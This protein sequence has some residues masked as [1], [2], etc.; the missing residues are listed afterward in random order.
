MPYLDRLP[1]FLKIFS[2]L[3]LVSS[4]AAHLVAHRIALKLKQK[5]WS[6][7]RFLQRIAQRPAGPFGGC[8][9]RL[10]AAL[11]WR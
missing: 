7:K 9:S 10:L 8:A 4:V 3:C 1:L 2:G 11:S 6:G 5:E